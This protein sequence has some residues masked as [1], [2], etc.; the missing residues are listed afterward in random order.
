MH[1]LIRVDHTESTHC[2]SIYTPKKLTC[3][4]KKG[5][6]SIGNETSFSPIDFHGT[7]VL[8][9]L[10]FPSTLSATTVEICMSLLTS[11]P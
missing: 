11:D 10:G 9:F 5:T 1:S 3:T 8:A 7:F 6:I 4:R 2:I